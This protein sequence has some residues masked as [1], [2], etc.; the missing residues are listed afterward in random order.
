MTGGCCRGCRGAMQQEAS[1]ESG[2]ALELDAVAAAIVAT[3]LTATSSSW[4]R[5]PE[6]SCAARDDVAQAPFCFH[7]KAHLGKFVTCCV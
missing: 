2:A 5:Q 1:G 3:G 4:R 7:G 6:A